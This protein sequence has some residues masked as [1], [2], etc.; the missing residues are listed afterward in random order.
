MITSYS[1][2]LLFLVPKEQSLSK[3]LFCHVS[4]SIQSLLLKTLIEVKSGSISKSYSLRGEEVEEEEEENECNEYGRKCEKVTAGLLAARL[5]TSPFLLR[6]FCSFFTP[7]SPSPPTSIHK[8][9][10][11]FSRA[12][13][14]AQLAMLSAVCAV[15]LTLGVKNKVFWNRSTNSRA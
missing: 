9:I 2:S 5:V 11:S 12:V 8:A 10:F 4:V 7:L 6:L 15:S 3:R 1:F 14:E 13:F